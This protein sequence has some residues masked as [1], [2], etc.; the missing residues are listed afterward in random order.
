MDLTGLRLIANPIHLSEEKEKG[1]RKVVASDSKSIDIDYLDKLRQTISIKH[2]TIY[3]SEFNL[4][5]IDKNIVF[6]KKKSFETERERRTQEPVQF[7]FQFS[8]PEEQQSWTFEAPGST[9]SKSDY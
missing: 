9:E 8:F 5:Y 1:S 2:P 3:L 6:K 7:S 4:S